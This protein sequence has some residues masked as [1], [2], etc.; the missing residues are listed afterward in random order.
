MGVSLRITTGPIWIMV[1]TVRARRNVKTARC[2]KK[3]NGVVFFLLF[4]KKVKKKNVGIVV[5]YGSRVSDSFHRFFFFRF[6]FGR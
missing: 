6:R 4:T 2:Q 5:D 3:K 1:F